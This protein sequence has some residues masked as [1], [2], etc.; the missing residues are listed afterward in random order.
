MGESV[1]SFFLSYNLSF[2]NAHLCPYLSITLS[3][4]P[5]ATTAASIVELPGFRG[6]EAVELA[7]FRG[8][9]AVELT[10]FRGAGVV[11]LAVLYGAGFAPKIIAK[12]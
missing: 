11:E 4:P 7:G 9:E 1:F 5:A 2:I 8:A 3:I 6:A 12:K 10:G